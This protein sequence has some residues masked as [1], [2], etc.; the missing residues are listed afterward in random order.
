MDSG[1][2]FELERI[3][4][5]VTIESPLTF[6]FG[7]RRVQVGGSNSYQLP[8]VP[9][10]ANPLVAALQMQL[11]EHCYCRRFAGRIIDL[12]KPTEGGRDLTADLAHANAGQER[13]E[14]GWLIVQVLPSGQIAVQRN[15]LGRLLWP[16]EY[17]A[18]DGSSG[19]PRRGTFVSVYCKK[20]STTLQPGFYFAFGEALAD[21][22][23]ETSPLRFYWNIQESG[24]VELARNITRELN[25]FQVPFR[26]KCLTNSALYDRADVAV[27]YVAKRSYRL[28]GNLIEGPYQEIAKYLRPDTPLF[29]KPLAPGLG[30][31]EDPANGESFGS[32]RCRLVAE[33]ICNAEAQGLR[34]LEA[35]IEAV[36]K[37]FHQQG[38]TLVA[39]YL[40][41]GSIDAYHWPTKDITLT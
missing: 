21:Q 36:E 39:P 22:S 1:P 41:R 16:G 20:H 9:P 18:P 35:R 6:V 2:K 19:M 26:L 37:Q 12:P 40:G 8:N 7:G 30:L 28:V 38:L 24:I 5:T 23:D 33:A 31:A 11:Y 14:S 3:L 29:A 34:A 25:R 27:L 32:H 10:V 15:G 17:L 13:W 4:E